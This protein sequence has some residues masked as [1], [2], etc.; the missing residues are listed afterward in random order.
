VFELTEG[1]IAR[2][3]KT[4]IEF[5]HRLHELGCGLSIDDFGTG[6][7]SF[8]YLRHFPVD[9]LK[10]DRAFVTHLATDLADRKIAKVLIEIAHTFGLQALAEGVEDAPTVAVLT[11]LGCNAVQGWFYAKAMPADEAIAWVEAFNARSAHPAGR[12]ETA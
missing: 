7:S 9:E 8:S 4:T 5:M 2:N 1:S 6:Y 11:E 12:L 3:E 10:I